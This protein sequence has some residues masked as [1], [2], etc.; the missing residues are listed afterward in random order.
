MESEES[1]E[2]DPEKAD[3]ARSK[4]DRSR[5]IFKARGLWKIY[6]MGEVNVTALRDVDFDLFEGE[7]LVLLGASGSGKDSGWR[8]VS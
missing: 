2:A 6:D 4:M 8:R 5:Q 3:T 7:I 1:R